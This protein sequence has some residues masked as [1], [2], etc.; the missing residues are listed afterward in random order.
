[1]QPLIELFQNYKGFSMATQNPVITIIAD[2]SA[3]SPLEAEHGF[4]CLIE[5]EGMKPL[6][7]DT[8]R[9]VLF[10]N[11]AELGKNLTDV[12]TLVLSHGHYDH[13]DA[14]TD[15]FTLN[16]TAKLI[17]S[18]HIFTEHYSMKTGK[19]RTIGLSEEN[20]QTIKNLPDEQKVFV[21][22]STSIPSYGITVYESIPQTNDLEKPSA[23][24]YCNKECTKSDTMIDE[25]VISIETDKGL[26]LITGCCHCGFMNMCSHVIEETKG[27]HIHSVIGGFHLAGVSK[28]RMDATVNFIREHKIDAVYPCHCTGEREM[29]MMETALPSI[30]QKAYC[31]F[32]ISF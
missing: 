6:L 30:V 19:L 13:T 4:S 7:F 28:E 9:G 2:N 20:A 12:S 1:M 18:E 27:K 26:V 14:L 5:F 32:S 22:K 15:F 11:A 8:G 24:L 21:K 10:H 23:L 3:S 29:Q 17:C 16:T 25:A 31:G